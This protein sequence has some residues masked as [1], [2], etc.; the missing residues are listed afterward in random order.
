MTHERPKQY[1]KYKN[2]EE[3][4]ATRLAQKRAWYYR[5]KE[6]DQQQAQEIVDL[7]EKNLV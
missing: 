3:R 5:Q 6:K 2:D 7:A 4:R 1:N